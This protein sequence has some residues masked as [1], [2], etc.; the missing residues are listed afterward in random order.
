MNL[1]NLFLNY[2]NDI[3]DKSIN[4]KLKTLEDNPKYKNEKNKG[5]RKQILSFLKSQ[6]VLTSRIN[7]YE[8][9]FN[10]TILNLYQE[11]INDISG[12]NIS[13]ENIDSILHIKNNKKGNHSEKNAI[14]YHIENDE[15]EYHIEKNEI[16]YH[17]ENN[18]T[19]YHIEND[20]SE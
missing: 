19:E 2:I 20:E 5:I 1:K 6:R 16:E 14:E 17:I 12:E 3:N 8:I 7:D 15:K 18:E 9:P 4:F 13:P 11:P 10:L